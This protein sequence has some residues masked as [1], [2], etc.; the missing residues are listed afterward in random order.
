MA[1]FKAIRERLEKATD[2]PWEIGGP[3]PS[4]SVLVLVDGG[5][6][7]PEPEPPIWEPVCICHQSQDFK[8]IMPSAENDADFIAHARQD[9]PDLLDAFE[10]VIELIKDT[11]EGPPRSGISGEPMPCWYVMLEH[12]LAKNGEG[13]EKVSAREG[14]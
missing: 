7:F 10:E 14:E 3:S 8:T 12:F 13:K 4:V 2:G 11:L 5:H 1:D 6:G 9:I